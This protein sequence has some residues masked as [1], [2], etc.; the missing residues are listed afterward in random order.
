MGLFEF[1]ESSFLSSL[2][3]LNISPLSDLGLA[4]ILSQSVGVLF[5]LLT[6]KWVF[7]RINKIDKTL[8]K[9][10]KGI[11]INKIRNEKGDITKEMKENQKIISLYL[12]KHTQAHAHTHTQRHKWK[13]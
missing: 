4:K 13:I 6:Q 1:L 7:E 9:Q 11:Q 12:K 2:Y 8:T 10:T 5:V 3:I